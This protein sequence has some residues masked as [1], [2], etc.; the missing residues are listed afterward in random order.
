MLLALLLHTQI[1]LLA[2]ISL[3]WMAWGLEREHTRQISTAALLSSKA[4]LTFKGYSRAV[5]TELP[6]SVLPVPTLIPSQSSTYQAF[7]RGKLF[8]SN[9]TSFIKVHRLPTT[10]SNLLCLMHLE[11]RFLKPCLST[12]F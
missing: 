5:L 2:Y 10:N 4:I 8:K 3:Q 12:S 9:L 7:S 1:W 6:I 11:F